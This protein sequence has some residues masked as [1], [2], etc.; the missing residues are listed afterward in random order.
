MF[1]GQDNDSLLGGDGRDILYG[2]LGNDTLYGGSA[3]DMLYGG[4]GNDVL[5]GG[6]GVDTLAGNRGNDLMIG[7]T[8]GDIFWMGSPDGADTI[9]D[10][11]YSAGDRMRLSSGI[12]WSAADVNSVAVVTFSTGGTVTLTGVTS[13]SV[14]DGWFTTG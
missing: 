5:S 2:N 10:F 1:A 9:S 14:V 3:P 13:S 4:Q 6:Q 8:G 12:T 11:D 7:G